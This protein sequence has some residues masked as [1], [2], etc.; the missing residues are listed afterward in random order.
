MK[1]LL[2][3]FLA[4]FLLASIA[5]AVKPSPALGPVPA[6]TLPGSTIAI[7]ATG[8]PAYKPSPSNP[9]FSIS[10]FC[11][12]ARCPSTCPTDPNDPDYLTC[13][14][15]EQR[16]YVNHDTPSCCCFR[17]PNFATTVQVWL[18]EFTLS[19]PSAQVDDGA[20]ISV[21]P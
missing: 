8:L 16:V 3:V 7:S 15:Y 11:T 6:T 4:A 13:V 19:P 14:P 18:L 17:M 5:S 9:K 20:Y 10:V 2:W 21:E 12:D 1:K